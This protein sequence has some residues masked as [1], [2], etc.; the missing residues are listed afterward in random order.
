MAR[1]LKVDTGAVDGVGHRLLMAGSQVDAHRQNLERG[2]GA[3]PNAWGRDDEFAR[4][5]AEQYRPG[6]DEVLEGTRNLARLLSDMGEHVR[7]TGKFFGAVE[8]DNT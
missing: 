1:L 5:F 2:L 8:H 3:T 7:T 6:H 4:K